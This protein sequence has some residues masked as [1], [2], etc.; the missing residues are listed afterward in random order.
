MSRGEV[1]TTAER[2]AA[3][4][5]QARQGP[6][7]R[8]DGIDPHLA[9]LLSPTS[10]E[11]EQYRVLRHIVE[12]Q[13]RSRGLKVLGVTSPIGGDGK[14]TT[15]LN[16]AGS[17]ANAP[18]RRVLLIDGDLRRPSI[19]RRLGVQQSGQPGLVEAIV[20]DRPLEE[21]VRR[22]PPFNL[23]VLTAGVRPT[24]SYEVL[25]SPR[26][27][28]LLD[29][30]RRDFDYVV[31]DTPPLLLVP[32][33]R[34]LANWVDGFL[35]VTAAHKTPRKL[36]EEALNVA[37][38]EKLIGIVFNGDDRPLFGYSKYYRS[39]YGRPARAGRSTWRTLFWPWKA[40]AS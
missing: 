1:T 7:L 30:A 4:D 5:A 11:A 31:L 17:L 33:C 19:G 10:F 3:S 34:L 25:H 38:P 23:W 12:E 15:A 36:L 26:V 14:T 32:D 2:S 21:V 37:D 20:D 6:R 13:H 39:Y 8:R 27:E 24:F 9:S 35:M 40:S 18:G 28:A 29:V 22:R 16:L